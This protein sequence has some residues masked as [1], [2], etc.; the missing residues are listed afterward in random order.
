MPC[1]DAA[2]IKVPHDKKKKLLLN[3]C[4]ICR[5]TT[6]ETHG[7][8]IFPFFTCFLKVTNEREIGWQ[9]KKV[10]EQ[11]KDYTESSLP[12]ISSFIITASCRANFIS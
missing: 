7:E 1:K 8:N 11:P 2:E 9:I 4:V 5:E 10:T 6:A 12:F 3:K